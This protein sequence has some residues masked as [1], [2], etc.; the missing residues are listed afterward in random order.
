MA[1]LTKP[2]PRWSGVFGELQSA[3]QLVLFGG[4]TT[5][6]IFP[7]GTGS[8]TASY[9]DGII[10]DTWVFNTSNQWSLI[11]SNAGPSARYE[12]AASWD[13][14]NFTLVGG[15]DG[16]ISL[17]DTWNYNTGG[18]TKISFTN[19]VSA[20]GTYS[21]PSTLRAASMVYNA[22][23]PTGTLLAFGNAAYQ[24][25]Y[26]LDQ[27][28]YASTSTPT[29]TELSPTVYP[30]AREYA[31]LA[32]S[33]STQLL[34]GGK[35]F[36]GPNSETWTNVSGTWTQITGFV[37]GTTCPSARYGANLV[38]NSGVFLLYGG[39]SPTQGYMNDSWTFNTGTSAWTKITTGPNPPPR[40]FAQ[41]S[42]F[43]AN[44]SVILFSGVGYAQTYTDTWS[45]S[46]GSWSQL[47]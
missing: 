38:Y 15:T 5:S 23:S 41:M 28:N 24:R 27:W 8:Q 1:L 43:T 25:H 30:S 19:T 29:W 6:N 45:F 4:K 14:I 17:S 40:A 46:S 3:S 34:F 13:G 21:I 39:I 10:G 7:G 47:G 18:W 35:N 26:V 22:P 12:S 20:S 9:R 36:D 31:A 37:P 32:S 42:N 33:G 11:S 44:S 2:A 16:T